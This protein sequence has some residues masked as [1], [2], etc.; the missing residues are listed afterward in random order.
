MSTAGRSPSASRKAASCGCWRR[1]P[2][3]RLT[4]PPPHAL[5]ARS[6]CHLQYKLT[7]RIV[8]LLAENT[9]PQ[10]SPCFTCTAGKALQ[11]LPANVRSHQM[12]TSIIVRLLAEIN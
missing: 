10:V 7:S 8:R 11:A 6:M 12:L 4:L 2:G 3:R 9:W 5:P 1:T